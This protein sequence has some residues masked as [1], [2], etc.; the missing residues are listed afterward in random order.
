MHVTVCP[1]MINGYLLVKRHFI[2]KI[3]IY[4]ICLCAYSEAKADGVDIYG[5]IIEIPDDSNSVYSRLISINT[6]NQLSTEGKTTTVYYLNVVPDCHME[7]ALL[8]IAVKGGDVCAFLPLAVIDRKV[9]SFSIDN[10][11]FSKIEI[12]ILVKI[13]NIPYTPPRLHLRISLQ[14][15]DREIVESL[16]DKSRQTT[17]RAHG[18]SPENSQ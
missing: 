10:K 1:K 9:T 16:W 12:D 17:N 6:T 8:Q 14:A 5:P 3:F 7:S 4:V 11:L 15:G 18:N 13:K 2:L